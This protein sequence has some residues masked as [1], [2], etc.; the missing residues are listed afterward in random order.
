MR[1]KGLFAFVERIIR[2][3]TDTLMAMNIILILLSVFFRY[4]LNDPLVWSEELAKFILVWT[5]FL[6]GSNAIRRWENLRVTLVLDKLSPNASRIFDMVLKAIASAFITFLFILALKSIPNVWNREMAPALGISMVVP[7]L[8]LIVG[9]GLMV[10][11]CIGLFVDFFHKEQS[12][13]RSHV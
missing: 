10:L 5:V 9:L 8:G 11:Q 6:A 13:K 1:E 3:V 2:Y 7:Q 4:V 12:A